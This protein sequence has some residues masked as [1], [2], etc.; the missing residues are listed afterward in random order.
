M[1]RKSKKKN[2]FLGRWRITAMEQWDKDFID[3]EEEGFFK[4][5][6]GGQG[7]FHFGNVQGS[8]DYDIESIEEK[9]RL[10]FSWEGNSEMDD[11]NGRGLAHIE[12]DGYMF[13]KIT[14]HLGDRSWFRAKR[15]K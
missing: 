11:A 6:K 14:F 15:K 8:I 2:P 1:P 10:E 4:F 13:G 12:D 9:Q 7:E 5:R 3:E